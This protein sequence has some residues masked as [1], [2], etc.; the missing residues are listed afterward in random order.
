MFGERLLVAISSLGMLFGAIFMFV[1][2]F[3]YLPADI[4]RRTLFGNPFRRDSYIPV[5]RMRKLYVGPGFKLQLIAGAMFAVSL[6]AQFIR[7]A[8]L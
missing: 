6:A 7:R 4:R 8:H 5:W 2:W 3:R 1:A